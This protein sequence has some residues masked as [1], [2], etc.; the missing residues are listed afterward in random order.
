MLVCRFRTRQQLAAN[1]NCSSPPPVQIMELWKRVNPGV[2]P[3]YAQTPPSTAQDHFKWN[4]E[5]QEPVNFK[6]HF[7]KTVSS[8]LSVLHCSSSAENCIAHSLRVCCNST[9]YS[10]LLGRCRVNKKH[11]I[12]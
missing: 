5:E 8:H 4:L 1:F 2:M 3:Q 9:T 10:V 6:H 12:I 11:C 7:K